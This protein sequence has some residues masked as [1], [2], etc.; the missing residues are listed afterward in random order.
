MI[1]KLPYTL[2]YLDLL[3]SQLTISLPHRSN[4]LIFS[5]NIRHRSHGRDRK[6]INLGM[7]LR[8]M[9]FNMLKLRR[10][11]ERG[12]I[13]IQRSQ[14]AM[15]SRVSRSD[16]AN[17]ALEMLNVHGI[18]PDNSRVQSDISL[19]DVIAEVE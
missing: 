10:L 4:L 14:P 9:L 2:E 6:L 13:P 8:I 17:I 1:L 7:T 16:I 5:Q 11:L 19:G 18:E 12:N 15:N 3:S